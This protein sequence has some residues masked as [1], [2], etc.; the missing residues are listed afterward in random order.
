[1]KINEFFVDQPAKSCLRRLELRKE[2]VLG[3]VQIS[4]LFFSTANVI[5]AAGSTVVATA[6]AVAAPPAAV[7]CCQVRPILLPVELCT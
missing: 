4:R 5:P 2:K 7:P 1:M 3:D 6:A